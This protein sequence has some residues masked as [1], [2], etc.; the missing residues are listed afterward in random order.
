M[1]PASCRCGGVRNGISG[2]HI[3]DVGCTTGFECFTHKIPLPVHVR[4]DFMSYRSIPLV[5]LES[6]V[7]SCS[8]DPDRGR[9]NLKGCLPYSQVMAGCHNIDRLRTCETVVL[10]PPIQIQLAHGHFRIRLLSH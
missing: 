9:T 4:I 7:V 10:Y 2:A 1:E 3:S 6:Y 5:L 8:P